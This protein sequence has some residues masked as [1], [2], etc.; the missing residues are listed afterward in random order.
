MDNTDRAKINL[1]ILKDILKNVNSVRMDLWCYNVIDYEYHAVKVVDILCSI[2][3]K[4]QDIIEIVGC[5]T[6]D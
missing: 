6:E 2:E 3:S 1:L 5:Y 4:I